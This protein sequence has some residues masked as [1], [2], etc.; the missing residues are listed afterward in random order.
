MSL[1][2][3]LARELNRAVELVEAEK[4]ESAINDL[5]QTTCISRGEAARIY[6]AGYRKQEKDQ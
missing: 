3:I 2:E 1:V 6:D 5:M 4:R